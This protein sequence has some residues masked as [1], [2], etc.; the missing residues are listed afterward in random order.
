MTKKGFTALFYAVY[1]NLREAVDIFLK[2][3][4]EIN[5]ISKGRSPITPLQLACA[6]GHVQIVASLLQA[7]AS[8]DSI[9]ETQG[10]K[11]NPLMLTLHSSEIEAPPIREAICELLVS[12]DVKT[13]VSR[14]DGCTA[15]MCSIDKGMTDFVKLFL[16]NSSAGINQLAVGDHTLNF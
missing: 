9:Y 15:L 10:E 14:T 8:V 4:I 11:F 6:K 13:N 16:E 3:N 5:V 2:H 7:G 12:K 1:Y